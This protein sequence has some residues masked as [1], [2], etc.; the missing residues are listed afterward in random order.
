MGEVWLVEDHE[1]EERVVVKIVPPDAPEDRVALL[2]RECRNARRLVHPNIVRVYDVHRE[3]G[4]TFIS[5]AYVDGEDIGQLRGRPLKEIL[6]VA[7]LIAHALD[8]AHRQGVVHRDLK[9]GNVLRDHKGEPQLIDFG[10]AGLLRSQADPVEIS[11]GGSPASMSPPQLAGDEPTPS[12]DIYSFGA[13]LYDLLSDRPE[14][15]PEELNS[16]IASSLS[17]EPSQR[18]DSMA[19]VK[20]ALEAAKKSV[21]LKP[22][23][24]TPPPRIE[25]IKPVIPPPV[26]SREPRAQPVGG[27]GWLTFGT[28]AFLILAAIAVFLFLPRWVPEPTP[29]SRTE[30]VEESVA[31][32]PAAESTEPR[33]L[34][35]QANLKTLAEDKRETA[36]RWQ[37][38]L[39]AKSASLWGGNEYRAALASVGAGDE[40]LR[41]QDYRAA[42][43]AYDGAIT[44]FENVNARATEV[45]RQALADGQRALTAGDS[46]GATAAF[47]LAATIEP[48]NRAAATGLARAKVLNEV[49]ALLAQGAERERNGDLRRAVE[50]YQKAISLDP[51]SQA[52][53]QALRRV[54]TGMTE[55]AFRTAISDGMAALNRRDY[56][57]AREA[58]QRAGTIKPGAPQVADGLAQAEEGLRLE[59]IALHR[60]KALAFENQEDWHKAAEQHQ[61][62]LELDRTIRFAREGKVRCDKRADLS[63]RLDFH[64]GHAER[65]SD[66]KVLQDA[67]ALLDGAS[68]IDPAGPRLEQQRRKLAELITVAST[69]IRVQLESDN[70]TEVVVY[71]V[72]RLGKFERH[73]LELRPG[74]Y[75]V[76][77]T[78][79]GYRDVRRQ[80]VIEAG[81]APERLV[82]RCEEKI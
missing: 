60:E 77:G 57:A 82:V 17:Q 31:P 48:G 43:E 38:D 12:D 39:D 28:F 51:M 73:T 68:Q 4:R 9:V 80:L 50:S 21:A 75:T 52:A 36:S 79:Q 76:V 24:V 72:G 53:R 67:S 46:R 61:A 26:T 16:L 32:P 22:I 25:K 14:P 62:V 58:F 30:L 81:K 2:K 37:Q 71:K 49:V 19:A 6:D 56:P 15:L 59:A 70:L 42:A 45:L 27:I 35:Q 65:L 11:G 41:A 40:N 63:D 44:G 33:D 47:E 66:E 29:S 23:R 69:P 8:Y 5:M 10:I 34:R 55:N 13:L 54:N 64:I 3:E 1:L 20:T 18:H 74:T 78:R 7:Q